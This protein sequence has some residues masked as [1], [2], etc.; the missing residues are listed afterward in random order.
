MLISVMFVVVCQLDGGKMLDQGVEVAEA[1]PFEQVKQKV[2]K[3][4]PVEADMVYAFSTIAGIRDNIDLMKFYIF[5]FT[6]M[7]NN[8]L[9]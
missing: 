3:R 7:V 2:P 8:M 5:V 1:S 6:W 4:I 9:F